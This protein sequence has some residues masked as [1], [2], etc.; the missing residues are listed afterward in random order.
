MGIVI[1]APAMRPCKLA[2]RCRGQRFTAY[3]P[4]FFFCS[5]QR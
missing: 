1:E 3:Q 5:D 4:S 2:L